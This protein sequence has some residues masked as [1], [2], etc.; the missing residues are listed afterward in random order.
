MRDVDP[1]LYHFS[2]ERHSLVKLRD[3]HLS[4]AAQEFLKD[5]PTD[6]SPLTIFLTAIFF[7]S[8]WKYRERSYRYHLL[9]TGHVLENLS[10][11]L[12]AL[13]YPYENTFDFDDRAVNGLLGLDEEREVALSVCRVKGKLES[14]E[15][16]QSLS[17]EALPE[18]VKGASR[19]SPREFDVS[20]VRAVHT[21]GYDIIPDK[22]GLNICNA[23]GVIPESRVTVPLESTPEVTLLYPDAV[24]RRRSSRNFIAAPMPVSYLGALLNILSA[25]NEGGKD[26]YGSSVC[27]GVLMRGVES[28]HDGF[29][30][31]DEKKD[32]LCEIRQGAFTGPMAGI[33]LD[34]GWMSAASLHVVFMTN[35]SDLERFWG[36]RGYRYAMMTAGRMG[37]RLYLGAS[38]LGLGCCGIGAFY[39]GEASDLLGLNES[40]RVLYVVAVGILKSMLKRDA[41]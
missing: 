18:I 16:A 21:A 36:A 35:M 15:S 9:D 13:G 4:G 26:S 20:A 41:V 27:T 32:G 5:S 6:A 38:A 33:C 10:L 3:G 31:T 7:R 30:L 12:K 23:L 1:G 37:E 40:S 19:V 34:Q 22:R 8:A 17:I 2:I 24:F 29:Y 28:L 14:H 39:D 25:K 11:S